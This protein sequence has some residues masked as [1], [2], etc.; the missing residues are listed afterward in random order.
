M[1][2]TWKLLQISLAYFVC[3]SEGLVQCSNF[4]IFLFFDV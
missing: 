1:V 2:H 3:L 4:R